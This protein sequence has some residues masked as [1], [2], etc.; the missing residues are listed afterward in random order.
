MKKFTKKAITFALTGVLGLSTMAGLV[1]CDNEKPPVDPNPPIVIP[2]PNPP[3]DPKPV[4]PEIP[5]DAYDEFVARMGG[6]NCYSYTYTKNGRETW[7]KFQGDK[8]VVDGYKTFLYLEKGVTYQLSYDETEEKYRKTVSETTLDVESYILSDLNL[9]VLTSYDEDSEEYTVSMAGQTWKMLVSDSRLVLESGDVQHKVEAVDLINVNL[10]SQDKIIDDT[11]SID[12]KPP[13]VEPDDPIV[14]DKVYTINAQGVRVYNSKLLAETIKEALN[15]QV[16]NGTLYGAITYGIGTTV[17]EVLFISTQGEDIKIGA[18]ASGAG[19]SGKT[20]GIFTIKNDSVSTWSENKQVWIDG[21]V[22]NKNISVNGVRGVDFKKSEENKEQLTEIF[23]KVLD[24]YA[25]N[26]VQAQS[27]NILGTPI[28][29]FENSTVLCVYEY[30]G[31]QEGIAALDMGNIHHIGLVGVVIDKN[32]EP[33]FLN[34]GVAT[35][36]FVSAYDTILNTN[37]SVN[38]EFIVFEQVQ[39]IE[40]NKDFYQ[41]ES[42]KEK[43]SVKAKEVALPAGRSKE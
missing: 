37:N 42:S 12:P 38:N 35:T 33:V 4:E 16:G 14:E 25:T 17:D 40:A 26:G 34:L 22:K 9:A 18:V 27:K 2:D 29:R 28:P 24:K 5:T 20:L 8:M 32:G 19:A 23:E 15:T 43:N 21:F 10:P 3:V 11:T 31:D 39:K 30:A 6:N 1:A 13:V 41:K 36:D 7:Y